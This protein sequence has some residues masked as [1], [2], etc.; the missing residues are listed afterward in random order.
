MDKP[1]AATNNEKHPIRILIDAVARFNPSGSNLLNIAA[2]TD[3]GNK[4]A[5]IINIIPPAF[6]AFSPAKL[7]SAITA[8]NTNNNSLIVFLALDRS[9]S[10]SSFIFFIA[11]TI[12]IIDNDTLIIITPA[13]AAYFPALLLANITRQNVPNIVIIEPKLDF[14][15]S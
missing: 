1:D 4:A 6:N 3:I 9:S 8:P 11:L 10:L 2:T 14:I 13:L 5:L 15:L 12:I 7:E